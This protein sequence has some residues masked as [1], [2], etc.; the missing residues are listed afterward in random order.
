[1]ISF[2]NMM[3]KTKLFLSFGI[4]AAV[5]FI[6]CMVGYYIISNMEASVEKMHT[7]IIIPLEEIAQISISYQR[8]RINLRDFISTENLQ[9]KEKYKQKMAELSDVIRKTSDSFEKTIISE[10]G[11]QLF[12]EFKLAFDSYNG[13]IDKLMQL[14]LDGKNQE[15]H[16]LMTGAAKDV[17]LKTQSFIDKLMDNKSEQGRITKLNDSSKAAMAKRI[18]TGLLIFSL[19]VSVVLGIS[20]ERGI[21]APISRV[22]DI[23]RELG[24]GN[25]IVDILVDR[26]DETGQLLGEM[27]ILIDNLKKMFAE[28]SKNVQT[29][30]SSSD[31]MTS[32][33]EHLAESAHRTSDK[34]LQLAAASEETTTSIQAVA[35]AMEQSTTNSSMIAS[36]TVEMNATVD[37]IAQNTGKAK[38]ISERAVVQS[39]TASQRVSELGGSAKKIG[40]VS[41]TIAEISEQTNLLALNATIEAARAGEAGKG[42][43]VVANEIKELARQTSE[44]TIEIKDHI[45]GIQVATET[46]ISDIS[47][48][49]TV[50]SEISDIINGIAAS[51]EE[52]AVTTGEISKNITQAS[53]G[54]SEVNENMNQS[55]GVI[56][57]MAKNITEVSVETKQVEEISIKIQANSKSLMALSQDLKTYLSR[58]KYEEKS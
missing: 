54:I 2:K 4:L 45:N 56:S 58:Y 1:M 40:L 34:T 19:V 23:A 25:F 10:E 31:E 9:E 20:I 46:T 11:K 14:N 48:I 30:A 39:Q 17:A 57:E 55:A 16:D 43:A 42:F 21:A 33:A 15:T 53:Q 38:S 18:M 3:L 37:E 52:Q 7:R 27:R 49:S 6:I 12:G 51:L 36:A 13:M 28:I 29:V 5:S 50:I 26:K 47:D 24:R 35:A 8:I 32:I 22:V 44:A 41:E